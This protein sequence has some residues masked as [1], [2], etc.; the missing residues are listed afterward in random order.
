MKKK[1]KSVFSITNKGHHIA[2]DFNLNLSDN[3]NSGKVHD[4]LN[5]IYQ[6][7]MM[8]TINKPTR[9]MR[10]TAVAIDHILPNSFIDIPIKTGIIK[11]DVSDHFLICFFIP[12]EKVSVENEIAYIHKRITNDKTIEAFTENLS[13]NNLNDIESVHNTYDAYST[14]LEQL[15]TM[16]GKHFPL[17]KIIA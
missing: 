1:F 14:S 6:N 4:F 16:Y 2:G 3:E 9:V 10:T 7:G 5:L 8:P 17:K 12:S 13:E 11:S 15:R